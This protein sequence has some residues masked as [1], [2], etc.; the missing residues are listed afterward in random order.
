MTSGPIRDIFV[1]FIY[2]NNI[3][4]FFDVA[5][6]SIFLYI[7]ILLFAFVILI[8]FYSDFFIF[9]F[10]LSFNIYFITVLPI[11]VLQLKLISVRQHF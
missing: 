7:V 11:F 10:L 2:Y 4:Q 5:F 9:G 3:Y 8:S 1:L 6:I